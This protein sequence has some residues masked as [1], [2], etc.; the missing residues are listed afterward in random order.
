[1]R[2][3]LRWHHIAPDSRL[4]GERSTLEVLRQ[5]QGFEIPA[6]AWERRILSV[7]SCGL[8]SGVAR[9]ALFDGH[10]WMGKALAASGDS[11]G[12]GAGGGGFHQRRAHHAFRS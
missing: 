5:L 3:L 7:R 10:G 12:G 2:W 1:M 11:R 9:P 8:R 6:N 4:Q